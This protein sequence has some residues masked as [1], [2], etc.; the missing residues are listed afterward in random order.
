MIVPVLG[1]I[2]TIGLPLLLAI[3]AS[4][5][6]ISAKHAERMAM[7]E[8]GVILEEPEK[9]PSKYGALRNACVMI[10]LALGAIGGLFAK[11]LYSPYTWWEADFLIF[12]LTVLGGGLAFLVYF[13]IV[14]RMEKNDKEG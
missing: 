8:R 11:N 12:V 1:I 6:Q 4:T 14:R 2:C 5:K 7:I 9:K 13:F 3:I 10:G